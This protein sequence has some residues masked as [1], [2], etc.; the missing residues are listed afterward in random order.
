M[1][2]GQVLVR[3]VARMEPRRVQLKVF[4]SHCTRPEALR[5]LR[6]PAVVMAPLGPRRLSKL[7]H[8]RGNWEADG[9]LLPK[10]IRRR[11]D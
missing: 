10:L 5:V 9:W 6:L 11:G 8:R 4:Q 3:V 2:M 1:R 7:I